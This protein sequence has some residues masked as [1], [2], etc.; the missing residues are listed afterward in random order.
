VELG[1]GLFTR[2]IRST[3]NG[4]WTPNRVSNPH[5]KVPYL[6]SPWRLIYVSQSVQVTTEVVL[7]HW[8]V[9]VFVRSLHEMNEYMEG[10]AY[11][12]MCKFNLRNIQTDF[13][14]IWYWKSTLEASVQCTSEV[15][16]GSN[17][18]S[19]KHSSILWNACSVMFVLRI[20]LRQQNCYV[21]EASI[22]TNVA[23]SIT[24][25]QFDN[26]YTTGVH[27]RTVT[28]II[29]ISHPLIKV[30]QSTIL[31]RVGLAKD[32]VSVNNQD[33]YSFIHQWLYSPL[34]S[35]GWFLSFVILYTVGRPPRTGDQH[36]ARPLPTLRT[37]QTE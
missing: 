4:P 3:E 6:Q 10:N 34:L 9:L 36:V 22:T 35:P 26:L 24:S 7:S 5:S 31:I 20:R 28:D 19:L 11:P 17:R 1:C 37:A 8:K 30:Q 33:Y 29:L 23:R 25:I 21:P 13:N 12:Q 32:A 16:T 27:F 18:L 15:T 2:Y 14:E